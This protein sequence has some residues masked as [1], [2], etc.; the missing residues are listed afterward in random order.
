VQWRAVTSGAGPRFAIGYV[1]G[2]VACAGP[3]IGTAVG[4]FRL[5]LGVIAVVI[6][7]GLAGLTSRLLL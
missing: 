1:A 6:A 4:L 7:S 2:A 5:R 3:A